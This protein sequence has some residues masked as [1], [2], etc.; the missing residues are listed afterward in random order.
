LRCYIKTWAAINFLASPIALIGRSVI[1]TEQG[2][3][4]FEC[5]SLV[6]L[7]GRSGSRRRKE[8]ENYYG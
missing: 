8:E 6:G 5:N 2:L 4:V 7:E 1:R 3:W